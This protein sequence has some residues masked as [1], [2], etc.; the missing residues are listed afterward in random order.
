MPIVEAAW[1]FLRPLYGRRD[2][3]GA[4]PLVHPTLR[5]CWVQW[6]LSANRAAIEDKGLDVEE[7]AHALTERE[8]EHWLWT[9]FQRVL[10]R[11]LATAFPIDVEVAGI[12]AA[13]RPMGVDLELLYVH[14]QVPPSGV[15]EDG[16]EA[17]VLP[18]L[19]QLVGDE[20][21]VMNLGYEAVPIPGWP[22][23]LW[24]S[25]SQ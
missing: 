16:A 23:Q 15:W 25:P 18:L 12:G 17:E 13:A 6:W 5:L 21:Q 10:T 1:R 3:R 20:W 11:D 8:P 9:H 24:I 7:V 22:P 14:A 2:L 19:M 4:W